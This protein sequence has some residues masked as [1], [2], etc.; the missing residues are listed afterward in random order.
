MF[1]NAWVKLA[2]LLQSVNWLGIETTNFPHS[3]Y[4]EFHSDISLFWPCAWSQDTCNPASPEA[5]APPILLVDLPHVSLIGAAAFV[6]ASKL[7][8]SQ[9]YRIQLATPEADARSAST[10]DPINLSGI[11]K[12]YH[13][14]ADVFSKSCAKKIPEHRPYNLKIDLEPG[15]SIPPG[16]MY[17]LSPLKLQTLRDFIDKHL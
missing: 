9:V 16:P 2:H 4:Q 10:A 3:S 13:N 15:Q 11:P 8:G 6:H 1:V 14:F 12:E 5:S 17:S 7:P